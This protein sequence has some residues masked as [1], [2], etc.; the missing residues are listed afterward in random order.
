MLFRSDFCTEEEREACLHEFP[1]TVS[2]RMELLHKDGSLVVGRYSVL[3]YYRELEIDLKIVGKRL[4]NSFFQ[5]RYIA[6]FEYYR[7]IQEDTFETWDDTN[8][9]QCQYDGP[10]VVKG[11]TNSRKNQWAKMM[12]APTK[13]DALNIAGELKC[14]M[15]IGQ[16][17]IIYRKY[18]PLVTFGG[19]LGGLPYTNEWRF[20]LLGTTILCSG[21]YWST[22]EYIPEKTPKEATELVEKVAPALSRNCNFYVVDVA[23]TANGHWAVVEVNDGQMSGLSECRAEELYANLRNELCKIL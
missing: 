22:A 15:L 14:D 16:Q 9:Y 18:V 11:K 3:P 4:I 5:H 7:D 23:E 13:R 10:F 19:D 2:N 17:D 21:Y 1:E 12:F 8:F 6:D 20:F